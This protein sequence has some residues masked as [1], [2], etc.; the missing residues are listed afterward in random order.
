[1]LPGADSAGQPFEG[2]SFSPNPFS[3][4]SG[5][6]DAALA[7]A[8]EDFHALVTV[9]GGASSS[10][11]LSRAWTGLVDSLRTA[12]LLSPL[13]AHA[14][15]FGTTESGKTVE[16][17]QELSVPHLQGPDGRAVAPVFSAVSALSAWNSAARPVPVDGQ[18]AALAAARDGLELMV[19]DAGSAHSVVLRRGA[20]RALA[21]GGDYA[22][23][24]ADA[25]VT[26]AVGLGVRSGGERV[27]GHRIMPGDPAQIL[28]GPEL[29]VVLGVTPGLDDEEL[30]G[31]TAAISRALAESPVLTERC[32]GIGLRVLPA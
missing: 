17:T 25:A 16:K 19:L 23:P 6:C 12:R 26:E 21:T 15:D 11:A 8:L 20:I 1:M 32:D 29:S 28:G 13:I 10:A 30:G 27:V 9:D 31:L 3:G 14:G 22:P 4:D 24:W 7:T 2:R 18:K 5:E